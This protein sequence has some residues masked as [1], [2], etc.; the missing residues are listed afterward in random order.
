MPRMAE[1]KH[2][3]PVPYERHIF[4]CISGKTC[5]TRGSEEI[6]SELKSLAK[7]AGITDRIRVNK[8]GCMN[9]CAYGPMMVIYPQAV[10]YSGVALEDVEEIFE[11]TVLRGEIIPHLVHEVSVPAGDDAR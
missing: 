7:A 9:Q 2:Y 1:E 4:V 5:P 8:S 6:C 3:P 10:W 11:K